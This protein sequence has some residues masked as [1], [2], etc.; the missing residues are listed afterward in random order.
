MLDAQRLIELC[1]VRYD[2]ASADARR[3]LHGRG[4]TLPGFEQVTVDVFPPYAVVG[5]FRDAARVEEA[6]V[7]RIGEA[8]Q[9]AS[10]ALR[11]VA[12]QRRDG[13]HTRC[14]VAVGEVPERVLTEENGLKFHVR[15]LQNQN[16]GLF[17]DMAPLRRILSE[18]SRSAEEQGAN[19]L[20]LFA[21]TCSLSV[22]ALAGGARQVVNND[23]SRSA[24]DIGREN[25]EANGQDMRAVRMLPHNLFKSWWKV[26][27]LGPYDVVIIDPPTNQ[28]GSFV[29][30]KHYAQIL[31]RLPEFT[32]PGG[33]VYACLNSPFMNAEF[34]PALA[35]RWC[36]SASLVRRVPGSEDFP[37]V[38]P[39]RALKVFEFVL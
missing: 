20:N 2:P 23:M 6:D 35:A 19:V 38:D 3:L 11:G 13:R 21:F 27:Q 29:A 36:P 37:D 26:R 15:P 1:A 4:H 7:T 33:R 17:L 14:D 18:S 9:S 5:L 31:K 24:L 39:D 28:R 10:P 25:H 30:E 34:L 22:A 32:S 8:L 16:V 12:V